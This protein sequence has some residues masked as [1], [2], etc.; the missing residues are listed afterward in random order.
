[1]IAAPPDHYVYVPLAQSAAWQMDLVVR[2]EV[3][4][5]ALAAAIR[6]EVR[7]VDSSLPLYEVHTLEEAV[8][9]SLATKRLTNLLLLGFAIAALLLAAVGIYGVMA[10]SVGQRVTEFGIRLALG[11]GRRDLL[12]LVLGQGVRLVLV[13]LAL[14]LAAAAAL[15][16]YLG[17]LLFHVEPLDPAVFAVVG[18]VLAAVAV[19]AC[20]LP[21]RRAT[22]TD[23]LVALRYE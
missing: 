5:G 1:M 19:I 6:A 12:T 23:P 13:G 16:R 3:E 20:Y 9:R 11:A 14:G 4:P 15:T 2:S 18:L 7:A 8:A 10:V 21:A 17:S 22:R